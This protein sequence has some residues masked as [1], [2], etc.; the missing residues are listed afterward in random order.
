MN[1]DLL[2]Y[3]CDP[4]DKSLLTLVGAQH[5]SSGRIETGTLVS[6]SGRQYPIRD[7][8][9]R[10][11][12]GAHEQV[13]V[14]SF[15]EEWNYFN[16][17][18]FKLNWL[19]HTVKNTFGSSGEFRGKIV[20]D[21]GAGSGMQSKWISE[22][23]A[24]RVIALELSHSVDGVMKKN[25]EGIAN[26]DVIQCSID[27]P[28]IR[29]CSIDGVVMC[30]NV[31]QHTASVEETARA[32]WKIVASKGEFVFNCYPKNDSGVLRRVRW[33]F[34][35]VLR[36]LLTK[37]PFRLRLLYAQTVSLL[38]FIPILGVML[39]KMLVVVRGHVP[40]GS[41]YL[42]RCYKTGV[43]NTFDWYGA[44]HFQHHKADLE[45]R[46]LVQE[47]QPDTSKVLNL[48]RYFERPQPIGIAL[49]LTK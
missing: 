22:E 38:R 25:L 3:L 27:R 23:G 18:A 16:F 32:L 36:S 20:V 29:D 17:D 47:L 43:L 5:D 48:D 12:F 49:R 24:K 37:L 21:A 1:L 10:V 31:I 19:S 33:K 11:V 6:T 2:R 44:H 28:P 45:I 26:V 14:V 13:S 46:A 9:P 8:V 7:G 41:N 34:Y 15:G 42:I 35:A 4:V 40:K 39:E 30:H